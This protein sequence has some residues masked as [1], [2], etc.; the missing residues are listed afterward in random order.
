MFEECDL[1]LTPLFRELNKLNIKGLGDI[2]YMT[3][4]RLTNLEN[5]N[6][7]KL[8]A[9][10][11]IKGA[12][13]R[14]LVVGNKNKANKI[15]RLLE[16]HL[17]VKTHLE[18]ANG[19]AGAKGHKIVINK[20]EPSGEGLA[21]FKA[22]A[23]AVIEQKKREYMNHLDKVL[24]KK[25]KKFEARK[26]NAIS[27]KV[28]ELAQLAHKE[29]TGTLSQNN[30]ARRNALKKE[31]DEEIREVY[32]LTQNDKNA[33]KKIIHVERT[34][35]GVSGG[36]KRRR[37]RSVSEKRSRSRH[38]S[39]S[40]RRTRSRS[41]SRSKKARHTRSRSRSRTRSGG[42]RRRSTRRRSGRRRSRSN[43]RR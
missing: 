15:V 42:R 1:P 4:K 34:L 2:W 40:R 27:K 32:E 43:R 14:S 16:E 33:L 25:A 28:T 7:K 18:E 31:L 19:Y 6:K 21:R 9:E 35:R 13:Q 22:A 26:R 3:G 29:K 12:Q 8:L 37:R 38:K 10:E 41:R 17:G 20:N 39:S 30:I 23:Q 24:E 11:I 5:K 36:A